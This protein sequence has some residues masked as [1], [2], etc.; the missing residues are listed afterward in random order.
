MGYTKLMDFVKVYPNSLTDEFCDELI[1]MYNSKGD[2]LVE[3]YV[4]NT[5]RE[6]QSDEHEYS[7]EGGQGIENKDIRRGKEININLDNDW[8]PF[9]DT[10]TDNVIQCVNRYRY[11]L[12]NDHIDQSKYLKGSTGKIGVD[13]GFGQFFAPWDQIRLEHFRMHKYET[14]HDDPDGNY[15]NLHI[16]AQDYNSA[17]RF[18]VILTYLNDVEVGGETCFDFIYHSGDKNACVHPKKG[19]TLMF[20]P[21]FMYPHTAHQPIS[22]PK[23]IVK[24][25]M[26][27]TY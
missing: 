16:D 2:E 18:M 17:K 20:H 11:E 14:L 12:E 22:D 5:E 27:Y 7:R 15:F 23:Y 3:S 26:Q 4:S 10:L 6:I 1:E 8:N 13:S 19:T 9:L 24:T 21:S 25:H